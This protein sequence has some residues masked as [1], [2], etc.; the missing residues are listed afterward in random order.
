M[1]YVFTEVNGGI[2]LDIIQED[3]RPNAIQE[4]PQGE[5]NP[6]FKLLKDIK[7]C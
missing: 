4:E 5:E 6:I 7:L 3:N 2:K 1:S